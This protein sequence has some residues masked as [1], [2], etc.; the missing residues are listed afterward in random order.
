M[1]SLFTKLKIIK[2]KENFKSS[3][4]SNSSLVVFAIIFVAI[5]GY[6]IYSSF[7]ATTGLPAG[8]TLREPDGGKNYYAPFPNH[9][10]LADTN[11][12]P[13]WLWGQYNMSSA[14]IAK[15]KSLGFNGYD[16]I[17]N[18]PGTNGE[19]TNMMDMLS[20]NGLD[21]FV[22]RD[23]PAQYRNT[24]AAVGY[25]M[26]DEPDMCTN[27]PSAGIQ[28][29][30]TYR[31]QAPADGRIRFTNYGKG[32]VFWWGDTDA[33]AFVNTSGNNDMFSADVY[34][35]TD[36]DA[37]D[38]SQGSVLYG[39]SW[40][41]PNPRNLTRDERMRAYNYGLQ[42]EKERRI[43]ALDGKLQ[44]IYNQ[45]EMARWEV[46]RGDTTITT[47]QMHGA[48]WQGIIF[49]ARGV[50]YF[51]FSW[52]VSGH[53][54]DSV[55]RSTDSFW[56]PIQN[57][58]KADNALAAQLAPVLNDNFADGYVSVSSGND[59]MAKYYAGDNNFY[60]FAGNKD[61]AS[62]TA[63]FTLAGAP[64]GTV[65][66]INENRTLNVTNG[67]FTDNFA[68]G[69]T[70]HIYRIANNAGGSSDTTPPTVSTTAPTAGSTVSGSSVA[71]SANASDNVG[72]SG[73][74][75]KVDGSN[76]GSQDTTSPYSVTWNSTGVANGSHTI[77]AVAS[78]A[79]GNSTTSSS[80][81]VTVS[82]AP[83]TT[84]PTVSLTAPTTG[85]TVS[86]ASVA[87]AAN[88][89]DNVGVAGVQFKLDGSNLQAEDTTSP[90]SI[91]WDSTAASNGTHTLTAIARDGAGNSTTSAA[92]SVTLNNVATNLNIGETNI[93][94][95]DDSGN[96]NM[97]LA[98]QTSLGQTATIQSMSFYVATASG[99]L[100]L[101]IYDA[102]G[103]SGGPGAK[104]A[105]TAEIT[106]VTGWNTAN[107]T[108]PVSLSAGTYWLAYFPNDNNLHFR[109]DTSSGTHRFYSLTYTT[110]PA[111]FSTTPT[112][113]AGHWSLYAS[114][115]S[116]AAGPKS[117][118]INGDNSVNIT[119]LSLLLSS[120]GQSTTQCST[121]NAYKCDLS[122]PG[123]GVVNIFD[124]SILLSKYG[125]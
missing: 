37:E 99:K 63:T 61:N 85:S 69:N 45:I 5:G 10:H 106:P 92:V 54:T 25:R 44:P 59:A 84:P 72:V 14:N 77:T 19:P 104:K 8:V 20:A 110:M 111:T 105:E 4:F 22:G 15:D 94:A 100:R 23:W 81:S 123:D 70:I 53:V 3:R 58:A 31:S 34:W 65:T 102:S 119:D 83:D 115:V 47:D 68:D 96:G 1:K 98:Q 24:P 60:V 55:Q 64:S 17:A 79:A 108:T 49:G 114:L 107:V 124:L 39:V 9:G 35:F 52:G 93:L 120:Y 12:F 18:Q 21:A 48:F 91:N 86:G 118:D 2:V 101:G 30:S 76:V 33:S 71:L 113:G 73:V 62:K 57:Q 11:Y 42:I 46:D 41:S 82:N 95:S 67:V 7:A 36:P 51:P 43:D 112:T 90:Y 66:V 88:A 26:T 121:N 74:Q 89:A 28:A 50:D 109:L 75:F 56:L 87:V 38:V 6:L 116:G 97:L 80:V 122:S 40:G 13:T 125:T 32:V 29:M 78:D 103:P 27:C 16:Q 117:G